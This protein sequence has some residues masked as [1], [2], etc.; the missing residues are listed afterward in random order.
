LLEGK[1][2]D[3]SYEFVGGFGI[4]EL[5]NNRSIMGIRMYDAELGRFLSADPIGFLG[6]I[7]FYVYVENNPLLDIDIL[8]LS[9]INYYNGTDCASA[10]NNLL[11]DITQLV[12]QGNQTKLVDL[13][14]VFAQVA[15]RCK[16]KIATTRLKYA[17]DAIRAAFEAAGIAVEDIGSKFLVVPTQLLYEQSTCPGR[18]DYLL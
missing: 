3:S 9:S 4:R 6:G 17:A 12:A 8:G 13:A 10:I 15:V 11:E 5:E 2:S 7:N 1:N 18:S 14:V 16:D